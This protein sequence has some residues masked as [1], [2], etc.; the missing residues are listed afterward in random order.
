MT[1]DAPATRTRNTQTSGRK[2]GAKYLVRD[3]LVIFVVAIICS[4]LIKTYIVRSFYI[5]SGSMEN[6]LRIDDRVIVNELVPAVF[7]VERGDIVVF[8]DPGGWLPE[9]KPVVLNPIA[10]GFDWVLSLVGI[11]GSD[12]NDHLIKR[13]IGVAGD[14]VACCSPT[15]QITINGSPIYE[16]YLLLPA[17]QTT[18]SATPFDVVVP[19]ESLWVMGDNRNNSRDSRVH[20]DDPDGGFV[21]MN[22]VVGRAIFVSWP[23]WHWTWLDNYPDVF[24]GAG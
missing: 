23:L 2:R 3:V 14:H 18:A 5:P 9:K 7:P 24:R 21:R 1:D 20:P 6:T 15:G 16:P 4:F 17:G 8:K 12:A 19:P 22:K 11:S 13:V 10:A